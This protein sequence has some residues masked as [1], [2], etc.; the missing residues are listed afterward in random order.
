VHVQAGDFY[1]TSGGGVEFSISDTPPNDFDL[2]VYESD[3]AGTRG[4][5]VG[6]SA[7]PTDVENTAIIN[8]D[9]YYLVQVVYWSVA[10][11]GYQGRAEFFQRAKFPPDV[12][13]PPG[14]QDILASDPFAGWRSHSEMHAAQNPLDPLPRPDAGAGGEAPDHHRERPLRS[15]GNTP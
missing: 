6:S 4:Q 5:L 3:E 1:E 15:S 7:G 8:A 9:G 10:N 13:D 11:S 2:Y 12:D 14:L